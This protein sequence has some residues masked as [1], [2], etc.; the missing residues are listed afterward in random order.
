MIAVGHE[1]C[2]K[3]A[4][5]LALKMYSMRR[6]MEMMA[7]SKIMIPSAMKLV[8]FLSATIHLIGSSFASGVQSEEELQQQNNDDI[9]IW[10]F[11]SSSSVAD[12]GSAIL[13]DDS[14]A[15]KRLRPHK[16]SFANS[17]TYKDEPIIRSKKAKAGK[18]NKAGKAAKRGKATNAPTNAGAQAP[19]NSPSRAP[20]RSPVPPSSPPTVSIINKCWNN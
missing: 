16:T 15:R 18:G 9:F 4:A 17:Y 13:E 1:H 8:I 20:S 6:T 14:E 7:T 3:G 11:Q 12:D 2:I 19:T 10:Q 5:K